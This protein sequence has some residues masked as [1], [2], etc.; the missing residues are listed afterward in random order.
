MNEKK[1]EKKSILTIVLSGLVMAAINANSAMAQ[2]IYPQRGQSPQQQQ[3]D[4]IDCS[5]WAT[6][7]TG[8]RPS[9]SSGSSGGVVSDRALR[10]AARGAGLGA[11]GGAIGG[12]AGTGAAIG[13]A[14]GGIAGGI[15]NQDEQARRQEFDRAFA[16]CIEGRGYTIR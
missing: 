1:R 7:Q 2:Y 10:G 5:N 3:Q 12:N 11:I 13:A 14:V 15:R 6:Q 8:Y 16:A 4:S 9:A